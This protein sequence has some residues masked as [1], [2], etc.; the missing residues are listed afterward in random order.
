[1]LKIK[2]LREG[3]EWLATCVGASVG[4]E[5]YRQEKLRHVN[6]VEVAI[7][8]LFEDGEVV[9]TDSLVECIRKMCGYRMFELQPF[10]TPEENIRQVLEAFLLLRKSIVERKREAD[11]N[12]QQ[13]VKGMF[14]PL[15][16]D[17]YKSVGGGYVPCSCG[18]IL[19]T[20]QA[21]REH[22]QLGHFDTPVYEGDK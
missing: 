12:F 8:E 6:E 5:N 16:E 20:Q 18:A 11:S 2:T 17:F 1:M 15:W 3:L 7:R 19:Q 22:W 10:A 4:S 21:V 9:I 13:N 14:R